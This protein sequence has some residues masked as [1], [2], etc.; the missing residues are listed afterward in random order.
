MGQEVVEVIYS[1]SNS[2][3]GKITKDSAGVFRVR[4]QF[5]DLSDWE[6]VGMAYWS[7]EHLGT[8]TDTLENARK[9]CGELM[10]ESRYAP[11]L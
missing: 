1:P 8:F 5:W 9:L 7:Q 3:R 2:V 4:T 6:L 10:S 11:H